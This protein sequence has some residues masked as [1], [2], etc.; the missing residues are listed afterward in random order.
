MKIF[1][2]LKNFKK[3]KI[4]KSQYIRIL[5]FRIF[6]VLNLLYLRFSNFIILVLAVIRG[7]ECRWREDENEHITR[8]CNQFD[9]LQSIP[10]FAEII[11]IVEFYWNDAVVNGIFVE[12]LSTLG[13]AF[14]A[15]HIHN[16]KFSSNRMFINTNYDTPIPAMI[17]STSGKIGRAHV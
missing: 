5:E 17:I 9:Y 7:I 3:L 12:R 10:G 14:K 16:V 1:Q 15:R 13:N 4:F 8:F 11:G 2:L 6:E